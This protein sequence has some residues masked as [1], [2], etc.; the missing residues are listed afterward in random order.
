M[1]EQCARF[2][3]MSLLD[4]VDTYVDGGF[5]VAITRSAS[6]AVCITTNVDNEF[7]QTKSGTSPTKL[8]PTLRARQDLCHGT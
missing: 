2:D 1:N 8:S 4:S 7:G 6:L 3:L 5:Q